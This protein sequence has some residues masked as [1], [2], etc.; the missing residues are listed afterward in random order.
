MVKWKDNQRN[1]EKEQK[2]MMSIKA[3]NKREK[4]RIHG[5]NWEA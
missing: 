4:M 5:E 3:V 2:V 1:E